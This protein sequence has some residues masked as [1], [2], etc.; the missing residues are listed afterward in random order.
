MRKSEP[1]GNCHPAPC[2]TNCGI[3]PG[4]HPPIPPNFGLSPADLPVPSAG[5]WLFTLRTGRVAGILVV[6]A[7]DG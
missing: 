2:G 7:V 6:R 1:F 5:C 3:C 4:A